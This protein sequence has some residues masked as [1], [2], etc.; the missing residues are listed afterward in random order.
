MPAQSI[1]QLEQLQQA[2]QK[3]KGFRPEAWDKVGFQR[4]CAQ[5]RKDSQATL[6]ELDA[7]LLKHKPAGWRVV[8]RRPR[9]A[10]QVA[11]PEVREAVVAVAGETSYER[12]AVVLALLTAGVLSTSTIWRIAQQVGEATSRR[13][14]GKKRSGSLDR[15]RN[16]STKGNGR[17]SGCI[18]KP[19]G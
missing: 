19:M 17:L 10:H 7:W 1:P 14:K 11:T 9:P 3:E 4:A 16:R 12:A 8:G 6:E 13:R 18:S 2:W 15:G 5:A